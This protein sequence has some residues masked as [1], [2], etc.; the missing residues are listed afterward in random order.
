MT[1][2]A[3][4]R[5]EPLLRHVQELGDKARVLAGLTV[6]CTKSVEFEVELSIGH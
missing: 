2:A 5:F 6:G 1:G 3:N 4:E